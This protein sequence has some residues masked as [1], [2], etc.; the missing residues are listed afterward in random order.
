MY[1]DDW[2]SIYKDLDKFIEDNLEIE[3]TRF[4]V[5][6]DEQKDKERL[7]VFIQEEQ[8][9]HENGNIESF[10]GVLKK[11]REDLGLTKPKVYH[12]ALLAKSHYSKIEEKDDRPGRREV[13][14]LGFAF[15]H[16]NIDKRNP[17]N[18]TP[19]EIMDKL[20]LLGG[21]IAYALKNTS[22]F[23]LVIIYCLRGRKNASG[24][25]AGYIHE[26]SDVNN[27]LSYKDFEQLPKDFKKL[28]K[29]VK[30]FEIRRS[31]K[32]EESNASS[33]TKTRKN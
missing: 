19:E 3:P 28:P 30:D 14:A 29:E 33:D 32:K 15:I 12:A 31:E 7:D 21:G 11:M 23:D 10:A 26:L 13:I 27:L 24:D 18:L 22:P 8:S 16:V 1:Q 6:H 17:L 25:V 4:H 5:L 2:D 20:L 9:K